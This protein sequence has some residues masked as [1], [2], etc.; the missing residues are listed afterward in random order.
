MEPET[1]YTVVGAIVVALTLAMIWSVVWLSRT[2]AASDYRFYTIRFE[3]QSLEGLQLGGDVNMRGIKVGRVEDYAI[4]RENIN[5]VNVTVRVQRRTPVS[6]NTTALIARNI[7]TGVARIDLRTPG[8]PGPELVA[9]PPNERYPVIP[10]GFS[11]FEQIT[12]S[13]NRLARS[14][15]SVLGGLNALLGPGNRNAIE[16]TLVSLREFSAG[17]QSRLARIDDATASFQAATASLQRTGDQVGES[18]RSLAS[19]YQPLAGR[20]GAVLDEGSAT[21]AELRTAVAEGRGAIVELREMFNRGQAAMSS[22]HSA[23]DAGGVTVRELRRDLN[24]AFA[25][26]RE[27]LGETREAVERYTTLAT[28]LNEQTRRLGSTTEGAVDVGMRELLATMRELRRAADAIATAARRLEDPR[29]AIFG[30][31]PRQLGPGE[32]AR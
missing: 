10:E 17:L 15:D 12:E 11:G 7:V 18:V 2:G 31:G 9:V 6:E 20:A 19:A 29:S 26:T 25:R 24:G 1:R 23:V 28:S 27:V 30:P 14:A 8:V 5:Q 16:Q 32:T 21:L 22:L 4:E 13:A 3:R